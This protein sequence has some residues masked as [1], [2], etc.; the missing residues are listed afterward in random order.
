V[1][2]S[3]DRSHRPDDFLV[4]REMPA[5]PFCPFCEGNEEKSSSE[6]WASRPNSGAPDTPG[7]LI[8]VVPNKF[9]ALKVEGDLNREGHG[10]YDTMNGVGAH[11][12]IIET[13]QHDL[14]IADMPL[15]QLE[16]V[17]RT[18]R[19]RLCDLFN[20]YRLRY[21]MIFKNHGLA[22]GA[23][24]AHPHTQ[25]IATPVTPITVAMEL[26]SAMDHFNLKE[27][28]LFCDIIHSELADGT[29]VIAANDDYVALAPFASRFPFEIFLAP[30]H[31]RH[32]FAAITD[33]E[34]Q[35]LAEFFRDIIRRMK[36]A[37]KDPPYNFIFHTAPNVR[38]AKKR[39]THWHSIEHDFHW[40]IEILPRLT[41]VAGFEWGTGLYINP[42][43]PEEA[44]R[45]LREPE[46]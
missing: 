43:A 24:L 9:P 31:H 2:I 14:S 39:Y 40:H 10:I 8:R 44:A 34:I 6:I 21:V 22:A 23:T 13:P 29:R 25:L 15:P 42:T 4:D 35:P 32:D 3:T 1:I 45:S 11:E 27:R 46:Q 37:L 26:R 20:D 38:A 18:Y 28:C 19:E 36:V 30:R 16:L 12:V 33:A 41:R 5:S 17:L 7:W